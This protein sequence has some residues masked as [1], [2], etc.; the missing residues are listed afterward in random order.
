LKKKNKKI[1]S[2]HE[3]GNTGDAYFQEIIPGKKG[4]K[5]IAFLLIPG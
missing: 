5:L 1:K 3:I 4:D 2:R